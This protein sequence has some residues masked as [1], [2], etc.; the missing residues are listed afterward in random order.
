MSAP[1]L[2][3]AAVIGSGQAGPGLATALATR[4]ESVTLFEGGLLGGSCVNVGCTPTKTLRKSARIAHLARRASDFGVQVGEVAIDATAVLARMRDVVERS[5][6]G[7]TKW[8]EGTAN[9][10]LVRAWARLDGR[11]SDGRFVVRAGDQTFHASRVYLNVGTSPALPPVPGL[12]ESKPLTNDTLLALDAFPAELVILGGSYIGLELGQIFA[13]LGSRVTILEVAPAV[14]G[15]EDPDVSAIIVSMLEEEGVRIVAGVTLRSVSRLADG[16]VAVTLRRPGTTADEVIGGTHL[17]A[18]TGRRARTDGLGLE[19]VGIVPD[20]QGYVIVDGGLETSVPG[21]FALGD[22]NRRGAFT[23]TSWQDHEIVLA[24]HTGGKRTADG[25]ITTYAMYTD[26][27]LGR[28]G[29]SQ[30]E[31]IALVAKGRRFLQ[32]TIPMANVSRAKEEG[33]TTGLIRVLV[34]ADTERFAGISMLGIGA[35]E[36]VQVIGAM[37]AANAPYQVLRDFLPVHPTVTEF[38]PT[39]LNRLKPLVVT[40]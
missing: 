28:I 1:Q 17:L 3:D 4:G 19:T 11:A 34:D 31:A 12:A 9:L 7:L 29:L 2:I 37:M 5:R 40:A 22:V 15:R 32:A 30:T 36:V 6:A 21:L 33:E 18:A 23:H 16:T 10:A 39:I 14:A 13:R 25:R 27:P 35:D 20:A 26:P 8:I 38:F 24:N